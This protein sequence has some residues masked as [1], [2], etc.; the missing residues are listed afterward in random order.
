MKNIKYSLL[1]VLFSFCLFSCKSTAEDSKQKSIE[2]MTTQTLGLAYLEE[3]KLDEAEKEFLKFIDLAP[4]EKLG[5]ANLGLA[6]LRMGKYPEA[7][8]QLLKGIK[9]DLKDPD[10]RLILA[11]VYKM[12]DERNRSISELKE[13]L[14][15]SPDHIKILYDLSEMYSVESD[16]DSQK[17]REN[18][19]LMLV[20]KA[21][22]N[23]VP[24]LNL[25]DIYI[26]KGE[27]DKA[28]EQ[29]EIIQK[30]FPEFPKEAIDYYDKTLSSLK[31]PDKEN[32]IMHF[33]IFHNY[34]KVTSPYQAGIMELKGPGGSLIGFPLITF[35]QQSSSQI[36]E[37]ESLLDVIKYT[38]VT[39]SAGLDIVTALG[40]GENTEFRNSTHVE[41]VDYDGDGDVDIYVG[42]YDP[43]SSSY[44]HY[45]FN[46][47]M[48]RFKDVS[49]DAGIRHSGKESSAAFADY[50]NDGFPDLYIVR[51]GG[52]ILYRNTGKGTF[53]EVTGKAEIGSKTGGNMALF[54][55]LDHDG[56]L[57]LFETK[58]NSN[59]LFRNNADG[60]FQEQAA[61][62]GLSGGDV[63]SRDAAFGDFDEDGDID[64]IVVNENAS[65]ILYSN[66]R[67]GIFKDITANSG[68]ASE[69]GSGAITVGDYNNDGYLDMFITS[70]NGG[71]H[72]LFRNLSNG[73][74]EREKNTKEM[75]LSLKNVKAYDASFLDFDNDGFLDLF[76]AGESEE[77]DGRGLFLYHND[78][79]GNFTDVSDLLPEEVKSGRQIAV[80]DYNEDGDLDIVIAGL[81]GRVFLLRNDGGN[82]N[83]FIKMKLV[84]LRAGSAKNN[85][86]GIGAKVE[87]R[88]GDLYQSMVV[89][90]PN[91]HF[92]LGNRSKADV[93]RITWTNGV[94]QNIFFPGTD[95]SLIEAQTLKGSC[96]F[97]YTW[98]G[99]EY[100]FTKDIMWRSALGMPLGIMGGSTAYAFPDASD[101]YIKIPGELL[102]PRKGVY[103]IQVT[104]ELWETIY[105]DKIQL[106]AVDHPDS[107]DVF[108]AEQFSPPPF[109]GYRVFQV[110][111]KHIPVSAKDSQGNDVL[112]Y[113]AEKDD[114]YLS[115]FK[116]DKYQGVTEMKDLILDPGEMDKTGNLYL[117]LNGWIFPTDASINVAISQSHDMKVIPPIIQV[118]NKDGEWETVIDKLGF[119]MGK[120]KTV[121]ADLSGKFLSGDHR[122]RIRTNME[123]YWDYIF[124]SDCLSSA[125]IISTVINPVSADLHYRG[126][127][128]SFRKGGRYGPHWFDYSEVDKNTK[129]RDLS[130]NYTRYGNVLPLLTESDNKYII[131]NAGDET[132]IEFDA[133]GLPELKKGWGRDFLIHSVGWVKDG[134]INT[135][136]GNTVLPLPFH[137]MTSYPPSEKDTYPNNPELQKYLREYNTRIVTSEDYRNAI[138][139]RDP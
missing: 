92:G 78:G 9:I 108:V 86:F 116:P 3:F 75:F 114:R 39:S 101:D 15:F 63:I 89:T 80:F 83:H 35:D 40:E 68:L 121:I 79:K 37:N 51:E 87:I 58:P 16:E 62:M 57:D 61:K 38:D 138:K 23:I 43:V 67:Q 71:S 84:G 98:N 77:K 91:V 20:E 21:P 85:H 31:K 34:L 76:I 118:I 112:P 139:Q 103:S 36:I 122:I 73:S 7:E 42:S 129:W 126:F 47:E 100:V 48:G 69:G 8:K 110:K 29:L 104:S 119:P 99:D 4:K 127:S 93:I 33:T 14:K 27:T 22:G 10:I 123:I 137:G 26:R 64:L 109:P 134:D 30:Q 45:L 133:K 44:K 11:T 24:R 55:D 17:Q 82:N 5:Y 117:F 136:H 12:N 19:I 111:E 105:F 56:D 88:S 74:F 70:V 107:V 13:A 66:Q 90:D 49:D 113:I 102:K 115:D 54:F 130:G 125:P 59:L 50:D 18:Y 132:S 96:P 28:L 6:Y 41:A 124:F 106:V 97:L 120:D 81:N 94:P 95:Q 60:T 135:A 53:E 131:S 2:L 72:E 52:D 128:R 65:N 25:T 1:F 32:A 46:N